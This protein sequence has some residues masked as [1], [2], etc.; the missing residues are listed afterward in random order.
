MSWAWRKH[1]VHVAL[2]VLV[3]G[4]AFGALVSYGKSCVER[5]AVWEGLS[6]ERG[7]ALVYR[8]SPDSGIRRAYFFI[9]PWKKVELEKMDVGA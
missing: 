1:L 2:L 5:N 3:L 8:C 4:V 6:F 9:W 7:L